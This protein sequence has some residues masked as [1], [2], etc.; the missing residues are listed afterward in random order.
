MMQGGVDL[1]HVRWVSFDGIGRASRVG[2]NFTEKGYGIRPAVGCSDRAC[3]AASQ[4]KPGEIDWQKIFVDEGARWF[5]CGRDISTAPI[6]NHCPSLTCRGDGG[7]KIRRD[8]GIISYDLN[9]RPIALE[10]T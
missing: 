5:H 10:V 2:L 1:S 6:G 8:E 7:R 3:S 9:F 4:L